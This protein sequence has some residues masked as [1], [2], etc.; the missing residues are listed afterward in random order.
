MFGLKGLTY[1]INGKLYLSVTNRCNSA[2][3]ISVRGPNFQWGKDFV[4]LPRGFEPSVDM[5]STA[6]GDA[7]KSGRIGGTASPDSPELITFAGCG[8]PL[9]RHDVI[10]DTAAQLKQLREAR[11]MQLRVK[12][13]GLVADPETRERMVRQLKEAGID[14]M[15]I[16]LQTA[17]PEQYLQLMQPAPGQGGFE[18]VCGFITACAGGGLAVEATAVAA[19]GV[20]LDATRALALSLGA[21]T[22]SSSTYFS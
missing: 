6:V 19:P 18:D 2:T 8:E 4:Q 20:D 15:A 7:F 13:N 3:S 22:F 17:S 5:L 12:T 11:P 10:C 16:A 1:F 14:T 21:A 9:L